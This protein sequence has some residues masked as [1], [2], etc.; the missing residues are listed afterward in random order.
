MNRS[1][2]LLGDAALV[3]CGA[4]VAALIG[5]NAARA[6]SDVY[7]FEEVPDAQ[8]LSRALFGA[9]DTAPVF[10]TRGIKAKNSAPG[11]STGGGA[12]VAYLI[13]FDFNSARIDP[14]YYPHLDQ[15]A[16][17]LKMPQA[18][19]KSLEVRGHTDSIGTDDYNLGLSIKRAE[20]VR[21]YLV[22]Q[23]AVA[24]DRLAVRGLGERQ[25]LDGREG[26]DPV[27]RRVEF[28]AF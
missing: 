12:T 15:L 13:K 26:A 4:V 14:A 9:G 22:S 28:Q 8:E 10:R 7:I 24:A 25:P 2:S 27:N 18:E 16:A 11:S 20:A 5:V 6:D 19:G 23:H 3:L 1:P 21:T 17:A